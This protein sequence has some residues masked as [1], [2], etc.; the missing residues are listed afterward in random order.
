MT[1]LPARRA[2]DVNDGPSL[3]TY[4]EV[5]LKLI[6]EQI[7]DKEQGNREALIAVVEASKLAGTAIKAASD[8]ANQ[9]SDLRY[10]Q[11]FEAQSDALAAAFLSQQ[12]AMKTALEAAK[13]AVN[14]ALA[15]ADRAVLKAELAADKRF[16]SLGEL[17][18]MLGKLI[19]RVEADQQFKGITDKIDG[20]SRRIDAVEG[21]LNTST[22]EAAGDRR[23]KDDNRATIAIVVAALAA[24]IA[25][26][27]HFLK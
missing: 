3:A 14:A 17:R 20:S 7:K 12:T 8:A 24:V 15:A 18:E 21:R 13:E 27:L 4:I 19:T 6:Q 23:S 22:G 10:Q 16:E 5:R 11:R 2:S 1:D 26:I 25:V 9:A